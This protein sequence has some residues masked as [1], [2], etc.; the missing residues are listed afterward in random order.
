M[1]YFLVTL[2]AVLTVEAATTVSQIVRGYQS[3]SASTPL[4]TVLQKEEAPRVAPYI[5]QPAAD[6]EALKSGVL[7][8]LLTRAAN[9]A[10]SSA[11]F[12]AVV[13]STGHT[14]AATTCTW[15]PSPQRV[16]TA[17]ECAPASAEQVAAFLG[18]RPVQDAIQGASAVKGGA[19][20]VVGRTQDRTLFVAVPVAGAGNAGKGAAGELVV[21]FRDPVVYG[22]PIADQGDVS[23]ADFIPQFMRRLDP[24]GFYFLLL[25]TVVGTLAGVVISRNLTRRLRHI[26]LTA[27]SWS[28]GELGVMV[29]DHSRDEIGQLAQGLNSMAGQIETLLT[30]RQ[31]LAVVEERNRLARELHDSVKQHLYANALLVRAARLVTGRDPQAAEKYLAEAEE[32]ADHAQQELVELIRA[33]RP[34][35]IADKGLVA[36]LQEYASEW[37]R[38]SGIE[39]EMQVQGERTTPLE[40]EDAIYRVG[41][42]ALTNVARHSDAQHVTVRLEWT[43]EQVML[44]VHDDG[45]GFD[46]A[47]C[48]QRGLGLTSMRERIEALHGTMAVSSS[49][50]GTCV[51]ARV[52]LAPGHEQEPGG[53][54]SA[55]TGGVIAGEL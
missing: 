47:R 48:E 53:M 55:H 35:S 16:T 20:Q 32:Q 31:Q 6:L 40:V 3:Y 38:R 15:V 41:Q 45:H 50:G 7:V 30:T 22:L 28:R 10:G 23:I 46:V 33:L 19:G 12:V 18:A 29:Q 52:P 13:D 4:E 34:A 21:V 11:S 37:S 51:E 26:A 14:V 9:Y 44:A 25:A 49:E 2:A 1:S 39:L 8:P 5:G 42:E 27:D 24:V 54:G 43:G 17:G 36:V